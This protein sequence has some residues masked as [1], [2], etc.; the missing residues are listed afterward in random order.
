MPEEAQD[1]Q[2]L[3]PHLL[4]G[5]NLEERGC[6]R[7][8]EALF[9]KLAAV[10]GVSPDFTGTADELIAEFSARDAQTMLSLELL[11]QATTVIE[12]LAELQGLQ[13][14]CLALYV[15][16]DT[17][18]LRTPLVPPLLGTAPPQEEPPN[19]P[20]PRAAVGNAADVISSPS[21]GYSLQSTGEA[22]KI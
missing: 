9:E 5:I 16:P 22:G 14:R 3:V 4:H 21:C 11:D 6:R 2:D 18:S 20:S 7:L 8:L 15:N 19:H 10:E 12:R 17:G 1:A 13:R